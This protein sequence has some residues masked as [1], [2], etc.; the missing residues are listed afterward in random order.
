MLWLQHHYKNTKIGNKVRGLKT[1]KLGYC[2]YLILF[3]RRTTS[4]HKQQRH[5]HHNTISH[6]DV[7]SHSLDPT[8]GHTNVN[9]MK[10]TYCPINY[11]I[12]SHVES[13]RSG[14]KLNVT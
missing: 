8:P 4:I 3:D 9:G 7:A 6:A 12:P 13:V 11:S 14:R 2:K 1:R 5:I 10:C